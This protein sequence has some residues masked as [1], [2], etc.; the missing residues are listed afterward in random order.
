MASWRRLWIV[1]LLVF[2]LALNRAAVDEPQNEPIPASLSGPSNLYFTSLWEGI[3][4]RYNA[5]SGTLEKVFK[6]ITG[7]ISSFDV[8]GE[9]GEK[10]YFTYVDENSLYLFSSGS[11]IE[12]YKHETYVRSVRV[13]LNPQNGKEAVYFSEAY[14]GGKDGKIYRLVNGSAEL[15]LVI[16]RDKVGFWAG[17]F[18]IAPDGTIYIT[19][20]NVV[21]S[22]IYVI[23][24]NT[25]KKLAM[26]PFPLMGPR[27]VENVRLEVKGLEVTVARGLLIAGYN[28]HTVYLYDLSSEK[29]YV[30]YENPDIKRI[31][32]ADLLVTAQSLA[33]GGSETAPTTQLVVGE[34]MY[35]GE[36][37]YVSE[38]TPLKIVILSGGEG[39]I[40]D[41]M[42]SIDSGEWKSY[43]GIFVLKGL[44]EGRH[45][46]K[47]FAVDESG[48]K[49]EEKTA[50]VY[51]DSTAPSVSDP[52]P[53]GE[54]TVT[55]APVSL[56]F[57]FKVNDGGSGVAEVRL[58][59]DGNPVELTKH[60]G[61]YLASLQL[62][63]GNHTLII[64]VKDFV[65]NSATY[66]YTVTIV[67]EHKD[68][69]YWLLPIVAAIAIVLAVVIY[70]KRKRKPP[71]PPPP[72]PPP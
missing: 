70:M 32:D 51:L 45:E 34:P 65:G 64:E 28:S 55:S 58:T 63:E 12:I 40:K 52:S 48:N 39:G 20:G 43:S 1:A 57:T 53:T 15:Y 26:Y 71:L 11:V 8:A 19:S 23:K 24:N 22:E 36:V 50:I 46:I 3:I 27:Y 17:C 4:Y 35:M 59:V 49:E 6:A 14:G 10:L 72:P 16:P 44:E 68:Q 7:R 66:A 21:P 2:F 29:L 56:N 42:Y 18:D 31:D 9:S 5:S 13:V 37:I 67:S 47:Y 60:D 38:S 62:A 33:G 69:F 30:V 41:V 61:G 54:I 25:F